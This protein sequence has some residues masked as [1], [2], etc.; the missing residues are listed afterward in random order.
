MKTVIVT[1]IKHYDIKLNVQRASVDIMPRVNRQSCCMARHMI[2]AFAL[3]SY[4]DKFVTFL[5]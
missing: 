4:D 1:N 3:T 2:A 5:R